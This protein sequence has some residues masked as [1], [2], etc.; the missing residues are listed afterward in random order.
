MKKIETKF[1]ILYY[2]KEKRNH[3]DVC[4]SNKGRMFFGLTKSELKEFIALVKGCED[5]DDWLCGY[6]DVCWGTKEKVYEYAQYYAQSNGR[7]F[8]REW[9]DD[10]YNV[11]GN[12]FMLF[13]YSEAY[14]L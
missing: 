3:Y 12:T 6:D 2:L 1:G 10:N 7:K 11:V 9:V 4:D 8:D 13:D 14:K 5:I